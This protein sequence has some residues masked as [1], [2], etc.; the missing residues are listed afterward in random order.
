MQK[1]S[2]LIFFTGTKNVEIIFEF[3]TRGFIYM[4]VKPTVSQLIMDTYVSTADICRSLCMS[5]LLEIRNS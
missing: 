3:F 4:R 1:I 5:H 2:T